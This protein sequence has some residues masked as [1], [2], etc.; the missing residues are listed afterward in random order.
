MLSKKIK[1]IILASIAIGIG[2][3]VTIGTDFF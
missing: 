3:I 1:I 2:I